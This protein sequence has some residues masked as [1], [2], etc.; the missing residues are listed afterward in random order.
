MQENRQP[1]P[2]AR[3]SESS[4]Y[5]NIA[6]SQRISDNG[7][8]I[9]NYGKAITCAQKENNPQALT[10]IL[11]EGYCLAA[12]WAQTLS[13]NGEMTKAKDYYVLAAIWAESAKRMQI[14]RQYYK[15]AAM[16][17]KAHVIALDKSMTITDYTFDK[18]VDL[19]N[20]GIKYAGKSGDVKIAEDIGF[21]RK[22]MIMGRGISHMSLGKRD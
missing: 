19:C 15:S 17:C 12:K 20:E 8:A 5:L 10:A 18:M 2:L 4:R 14:S 9:E 22:M 16:L 21:M 7:S 3:Q 6:R 1:A 13:N 11:C